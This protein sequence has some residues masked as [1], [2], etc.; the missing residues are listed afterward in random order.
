[1][2]LYIY[3][4]YLFVNVCY[5]TALAGF[6]E[7]KTCLEEFALGHSLTT[8]RRDIVLSRHCVPGQD[9]PV[10]MVCL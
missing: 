4:W 6:E 1:M 3:F 2:Q 5:I 10:Q 8:Q 9:L 7:L